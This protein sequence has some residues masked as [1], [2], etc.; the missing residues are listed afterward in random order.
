V[1]QV[2]YSTLHASIEMLGYYILYN[3][4]TILIM[5]YTYEI[6]I[7]YNILPFVLDDPYSMLYVSLAL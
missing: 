7:M 3:F 6:T 5:M 1:M 4:N 2:L